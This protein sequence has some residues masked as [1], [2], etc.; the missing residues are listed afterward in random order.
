MQLTLLRIGL[1]CLA[2][3]AKMMRRGM[4]RPR[5]RSEVPNHGRYEVVCRCMAEKI[6]RFGKLHRGH[7]LDIDTALDSFAA[8]AE[9]Y[10]SQRHPTPILDPI[11]PM[12]MLTRAVEQKRGRRSG[13]RRLLRNA[14]NR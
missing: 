6:R 12:L 14:A 3:H 11:H 13:S 5:Q 10:F 9:N 1:V 8:P 7:A 2:F 4:S